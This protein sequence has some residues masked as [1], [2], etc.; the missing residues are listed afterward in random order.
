[1]KNPEIPRLVPDHL[2]TKKMFKYAIK[3]V[4]LIDLRL[5]KDVKKLFLKMVEFFRDC[6]KDQK[7]CDKGVNNYPQTLKF[8]LDCYKSLQYNLFLNAVRPKK[9]VIKLLIYI[10]CIYILVSYK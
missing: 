6:Y 2:K 8:V 3:D 10:F 1:M 7:M 9:C 5:N 4:F